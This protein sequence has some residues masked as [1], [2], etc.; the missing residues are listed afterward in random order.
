MR[1]LCQLICCLLLGGAGLGL[2]QTGLPMPPA[3]EKGV[4]DDTHA[5][6]PEAQA[7][8]EKRVAKARTRLGYP[9]WFNTSTYTAPGLPVKD[10]ARDLRQHW[11]GRAD[12]VLVAYDRSSNQAALSYAPGLWA[13]LAT[14]DLLKLSAEATATV[15]GKPEDLEARLMALVESSLT[16]LEGLEQS[17]RAAQ[18]RVSGDDRP[19]GLVFT[20]LLVAGGAVALI[21]GTAARRRD[22]LA[23][24][25]SWFPE[26]QVG[27]RLG[28]PHGALVVEQRK[29]DLTDVA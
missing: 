25:Q 1:C 26:I 5:L 24:W 16:R 10:F 27:A 23:A 9:V 12:A 18:P 13:R 20:L 6:S 4:R 14:Q 22:A 29:A 21:L 7:T 3:P 2:A 8:L 15:A 28:A 19:V 11:S 17:Y